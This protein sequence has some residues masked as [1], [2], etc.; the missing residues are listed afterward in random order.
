MAGPGDRHESRTGLEGDVCAQL[1]SQGVDHE[2]R[3]LHFRVRDATGAV[4]RYDPD[5]V[6]RRGA[7]VFLVEPVIASPE[8]RGRL[9]LVARFLEQHS[10]ELILVVIADAAVRD[11]VPADAYD[12]LYDSTQVP[13]V[14]R[15]MR[16]Q[17]PGGIVEPFRK[18]RA[19]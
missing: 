18:E 9:A 19:A 5:I 11:Q 12:E 1:R 2:H 10:P 16:D 8:A 13:A 7:I 14:V 6:V 15:R 17:D 4:T 3:S